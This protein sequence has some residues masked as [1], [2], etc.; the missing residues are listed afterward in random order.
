MKQDAIERA[1][2]ASLMSNRPVI[3]DDNE[4][5]AKFV[6]YLG[7]M[8]TIGV[9][10]HV[11]SAKNGYYFTESVKNEVIDETLH[12]MHC[13]AFGDHSVKWSEHVRKRGLY[14]YT[15]LTS[16]KQMHYNIT[17]SNL[18]C[19]IILLNNIDCVKK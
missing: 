4:H 17:E 14:A 1:T 16:N 3:V 6:F 2:V 15:S 7:I 8:M 10:L 19:L 9:A 11:F 5:C 18:E 13:G 12:L